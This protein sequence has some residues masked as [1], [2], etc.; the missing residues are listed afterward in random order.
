M[1]KLLL[2]STGV[3]A[4]LSSAA[5]AEMLR[6]PAPDARLLYRLSPS[7]AREFEPTSRSTRLGRW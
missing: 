4:L 2:I 6:Q 7:T 1:N 5:F 3:A